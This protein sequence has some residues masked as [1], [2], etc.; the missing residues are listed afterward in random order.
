MS[1]SNMFKRLID[2]A[3]PADVQ[4]F[5]LH[6]RPTIRMDR[7]L[8]CLDCESIFEAEGHQTCPAC[9]SATA[10]AIGRAL[11]REPD[12][13]FAESVSRAAASLPE[14]E[15]ETPRPDV[16]RPR[17]NGRRKESVSAVTH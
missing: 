4:E 16:Q 3:D 7:A 11:N 17:R 5:Y 14:Q 1:A 15:V 6:F 13:V 2:P 12:T 10:W 9:G 8:L